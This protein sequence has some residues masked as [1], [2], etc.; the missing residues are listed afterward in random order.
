VRRGLSNAPRHQRRR[1]AQPAAGGP[2]RLWQAHRGGRRLPGGRPAQGGVAAV[3]GQPEDRA[4]QPG[5]HRH[6]AAGGPPGEQPS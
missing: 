2:G 4:P 6:G 1:G 3:A 5:H